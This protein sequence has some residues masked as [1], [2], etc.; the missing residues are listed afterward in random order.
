MI[1]APS[2]RLAASPLWRVPRYE[3]WS[4]SCQPP[5]AAPDSG[6]EF[7][8]QDTRAGSGGSP[9][10][11]GQYRRT[12]F[13]QIGDEVAGTS[14]GGRFP[15]VA[16]DGPP[17]AAPHPGAVVAGTEF[18]PR[19]GHG[20]ARRRIGVVRIRQLVHH[21]DELGAVDRFGFRRRASADRV[22]SSSRSASGARAAYPC[23]SNGSTGQGICWLLPNRLRRFRSGTTPATG[24]AGNPA[25]PPSS[26]S[27][28][29]AGIDPC[30]RD[31]DGEPGSSPR[32]RRPGRQRPRRSGS[33]PAVLTPEGTRRWRPG[34][35]SPVRRVDGDRRR[36]DQHPGRRTRRKA[37]R[38]HLVDLPNRLLRH[39][40]R[41]PAP[42]V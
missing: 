2:C 29:S 16:G 33:A 17:V 28:G 37:D 30:R 8:A 15:P 27:P 38:A 22:R 41:P 9:A 10:S 26:N 36:P 32:V 5:A 7:Q 24:F 3:L 11:G 31:S 39:E 25:R 14:G 42:R 23:P 19:R 1:P 6:R 35:V 20:M 21:V 40:P 4:A 18:R 12:P 34:S 13:A